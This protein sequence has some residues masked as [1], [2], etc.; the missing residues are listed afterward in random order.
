MRQKGEA[1]RKR[2]GFITAVENIG[3]ELNKFLYRN[4]IPMGHNRADLQILWLKA[5]VKFGDDVLR[6]ISLKAPLNRESNDG[7]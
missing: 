1:S 5:D 6:H 7:G 4:A 2:R 3:I